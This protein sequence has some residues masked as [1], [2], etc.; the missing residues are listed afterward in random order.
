MHEHEESD[1]HV[2]PKKRPNKARAAARSAEGVEEKRSTKGNSMQET[3][4]RTQSRVALQQNLHRVAMR[5]GLEPELQI[6]PGGHDGRS[7]GYRQ[8]RSCGPPRQSSTLPRSRQANACLDERLHAAPQAIR[9]VFLRKCL[10]V[11]VFLAP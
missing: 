3:K 5:R 2:V 4:V 8:G 9:T 10:H 6:I 1:E 11:M 7:S